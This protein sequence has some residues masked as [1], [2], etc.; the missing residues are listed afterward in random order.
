IV[1]ID[2]KNQYATP[3]ESVELPLTKNPDALTTLSEKIQ[4]VITSS[5]IEKEKIIGVGIGMPGFV[6][7][8]KGINYTFLQTKN[9]ESIADYLSSKL[10]MP[11]FIDND[12]S[13]IGLAELRFGS[14][15]NKKNA[16]VINIG[17]G[18]GL[19]MIL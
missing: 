7:S 19:G 1:I 13:L 10:G 18:V 8:K 17:W 14:A 3:I 15:R 11:V 5:R 4:M 6:D 12:S 16:M 9:P 2:S